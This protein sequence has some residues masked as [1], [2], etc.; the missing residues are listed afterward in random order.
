[1]IHKTPP[2]TEAEI[3]G[4]KGQNDWYVSDVKVKLT[5]NDALS[6]IDKTYC[7]LDNASCETASSIII[8]NEGEH[9]IKYYS[10]DKAGNAENEKTIT[11]KID[12]TAPEAKLTFN[13]QTQKLDI[14]GTDNLSQ[15]VSVQTKEQAITKD[16]N[17]NEKKNTFRFFNWFFKDQK[18]KKVIVTATLTDEA[19]HKTEIVWEKKKD[20]DRRIDIAISSISYDGQKTDISESNIQYKWMLDWRRNKY[21]LFASHL[22]DDS[23][24]IESHYFPNKNQTWFMERPN[25]L[26]DDDSDD[27]AQQRPV[28]KKLPGMVIPGAMTEKG[29]IGIRY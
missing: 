23:M 6:G 24:S 18:E 20:K 11:I 10:Q 21:L 17:K 8:Q 2:Q 27:N 4:T 25:D 29:K 28:W 16:N 9:T 1:M 3:T 13:S 19:G 5:A 12:K 7:S 14:I 15:N 26:A 22:S